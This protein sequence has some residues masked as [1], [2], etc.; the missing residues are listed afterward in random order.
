M[1]T[2][3]RL[4]VN[5]GLLRLAELDITRSIRN[6]TRL[7]CTLKGSDSLAKAMCNG[8]RAAWFGLIAWVLL[9]PFAGPSAAE[10]SPGATPHG[11]GSTTFRVWA[12]FVDGVG[13]RVT[14]HQRYR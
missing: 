3:A 5:A 4:S 11:D 10:F 12:P 13:V 14:M 2:L 1:D 6:F 7:R 8:Q 9:L